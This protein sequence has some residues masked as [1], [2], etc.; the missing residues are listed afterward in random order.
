MTTPEIIVLTGASVAFTTLFIAGYLRQHSQAEQEAYIMNW[1]NIIKQ[2]LPIALQFVP[3]LPP[4]VATSII[5]TVI[6]VEGLPGKSGAQK[7][8]IVMDAVVTQLQNVNVVKGHDVVNV[9]VI[10]ASVDKSID[11]GIAAANAIHQ[12]AVHVADK[13]EVLAVQSPAPQ[14]TG[15]SSSGAGQLTE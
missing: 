12:G 1:G 4:V 2:V 9:D 10:A 7:K 6:A 15:G 13:T 14:A 8:A 5:G 3:G 11:A